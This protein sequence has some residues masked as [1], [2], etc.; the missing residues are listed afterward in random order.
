M[1]TKFSREKENDYYNIFQLGVLFI[2]EE[3]LEILKYFNA[4][5]QEQDVY[6]FRRIF[7][8]C[9]GLICMLGVGLLVVIS[10]IRFLM[11]A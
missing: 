6:N 2:S 1:I 7:W 3:V 5:D 11:G 9:T 4:Y 10:C 8:L